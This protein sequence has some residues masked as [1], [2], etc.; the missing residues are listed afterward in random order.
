MNAT[1]ALVLLILLLGCDNIQTS[2]DQDINFS[3]YKS[4]CWLEGCELAIT[5]PDYLKDS[6]IQKNIKNA[7]ID[8]LTR[9]GLRYDDSNPDLLVDFHVVIENEKVITYHN[10]EDEPYYYRMTFLTPEEMLL[11]KGTILLHMVD[12][13][14]SIVVWQSQVLGYLETGPDL[15]EKNIQ[16]GIFQLL[17]E[18]PPKKKN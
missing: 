9:K 13:Q 14:K 18:F 15:S 10:R 12:R 2:Y 16:K 3:T 7:I 6:I 4:F 17:K 11:T 1:R 5:G 8:E